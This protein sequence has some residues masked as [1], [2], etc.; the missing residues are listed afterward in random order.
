[1]SVSVEPE[2]FL[3]H[4]QAQLAGVPFSASLAQQVYC[5]AVEQSFDYLTLRCLANRSPL[6]QESRL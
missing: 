2:A 6:P 5:K 1:M 3:V 4:D